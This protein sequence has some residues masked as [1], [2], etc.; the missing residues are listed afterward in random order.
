MDGGKERRL[1]IIMVMVWECIVWDSIYGTHPRAGAAAVVL[2]HD[3]V[4]GHAGP[5][6][7]DGLGDVRGAL[8]GVDVAGL[9]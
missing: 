3:G 9:D 8:L 4:L 2:G 7:A 5:V 1:G 6:P